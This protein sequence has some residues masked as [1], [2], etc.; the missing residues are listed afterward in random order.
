MLTIRLQRVG[1]KKQPVFRIVL[2]EK[3]RAASKL[4][5]EILGHYNP[6]TKE[7]AIRDE[8]R[9]KYWIEQRV[10]ISPTVHN[11]LV[12]KGLLT[13]KKIKAWRPK[14]KKAEASSPSPSS[15]PI[16]GGEKKEKI[17]S[18]SDGGG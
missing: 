2:A 11:L 6:Q 3:H 18:P 8:G 16:E 12:S 17:S 1:K 15:P 5:Q 10:E 14:A 4:A 9:L 13:G 7:F